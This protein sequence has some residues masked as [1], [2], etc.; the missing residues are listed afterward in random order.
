MF[1]CEL[2]QIEF[3]QEFHPNNIH[4]EMLSNSRNIRN[5]ICSMSSIDAIVSLSL[6]SEVLFTTFPDKYC[7]KC[8]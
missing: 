3:P 4:S 1:G 2:E 8:L 6:E 7:P 5:I